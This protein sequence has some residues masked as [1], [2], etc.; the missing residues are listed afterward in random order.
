M[1]ADVSR[2]NPFIFQ[3][4][5]QLMLVGVR[6]HLVYHSSGADVWPCGSALVLH[7]DDMMFFTV[8]HRHLMNR[9][10][11]GAYAVTLSLCL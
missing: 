8:N 5:P 9:S 6:K 4:A 1:P 2:L 11:K 3:A 7:M 10:C